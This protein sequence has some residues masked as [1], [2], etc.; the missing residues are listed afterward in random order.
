[1]TVHD[2]IVSHDRWSANYR[3][4]MH[5]RAHANMNGPD[6]YCAVFNNS[7]DI[8]RL[9]SCIELRHGGKQIA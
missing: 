5:D 8:L 4:S 3:L 9:Q 6:Y 7:L 1:M 2:R